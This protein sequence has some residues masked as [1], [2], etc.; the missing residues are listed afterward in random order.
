MRFTRRTALAGGGALAVAGAGG[1]ALG[2][3]QMASMG[4]YDEA[5]AA[6][7]A[8]LSHDPS[9]HELVR[10]ATLAPNGHNTQPWQ[11]RVAAEHIDILPDFARRTPVVDPDDHHLFVSLGAAAENLALAAAA[12][13]RPGEV[14]FDPSGSGAVHV[15]LGR[16]IPDPSPLF[17]AIRHR[18]ST[19]ADYDSRPLGASELTHLAAAAKVPGV[20]LV[21]VTDRAQMTKLTDLVVTGNSAQMADPAFVTELKQWLRFTP[22]EAL[23]R[24]DGLFSAASGL[25]VVPTWA[26]PF[27]FDTFAGAKSENDKYAGQLR[28]SSGLAVFVGDRADPLHWVQVGRACQRFALAAT[29][30]GLKHAFMNQPVEVARLR[31]D[32]ASLIGMPG[33]RPDMFMRFGR[34]PAL[35]YSARRAPHFIV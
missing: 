3:R 17:E 27:M 18:Q 34:G 10:F 1:A 33:R 30:L 20:D 32:L 19:R 35:P 4:G 24:G 15:T 9:L 13:G 21:I 8:A 29:A 14:S 16:G 5:V 11:F 23:A 7:R 12:R 26:G 22:R 28:S 31:P 2:Y 25:P 6:T